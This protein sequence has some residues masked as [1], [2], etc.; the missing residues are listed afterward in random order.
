MNGKIFIETA[1]G[2]CSPCS[3]YHTMIDIS[4]SL[5]KQHNLCNILI[6]VPYLGAISH[7]ISALN[8]LKFD[9][10]IINKAE[11]QFVKSIRNHLPYELHVL[12]I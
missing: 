11:R 6:A 10:L 7:T 4:K 1:G 9:V 12:E 5:V 8:M 3:D 2:V